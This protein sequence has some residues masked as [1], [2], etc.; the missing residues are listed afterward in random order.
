MPIIVYNMH[1]NLD[2]YKIHRASKGRHTD[3]LEQFFI[4]KH[5]REHTYIDSGKTTRR[6][7][8]FVYPAL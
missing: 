4:Q 6:K 8:P 1:M 7:Q 2:P 3:I 5:T